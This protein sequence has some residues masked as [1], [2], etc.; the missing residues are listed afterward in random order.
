MSVNTNYSE[1]WTG[2]LVQ[3]QEQIASASLSRLALLF[4]INIPIIAVVLNVIY[5]LVSLNS[6]GGDNAALSAT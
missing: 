3:A 6:V 5:Q 2:Y 1:P 4:V